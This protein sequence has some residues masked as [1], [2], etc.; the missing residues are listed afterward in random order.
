MGQECAPAAGRGKPL[1]IASGLSAGVRVRRVDVQRE[2]ASSS[3]KWAA[4]NGT[5]K[6]S[7]KALTVVGIY[8]LKKSG[9][10]A[11]GN[12]LYLRVSG[13]GAKQ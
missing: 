12:G 13:S 2:L 9:R 7:E 1:G 8:A 3:T 4:R 5:R 6:A 11:D 10:Y